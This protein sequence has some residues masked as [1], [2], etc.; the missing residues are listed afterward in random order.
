[1]DIKMGLH[2]LVACTM[3]VLPAFYGDIISASAQMTIK[4]AVSILL[5]GT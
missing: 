3:M 2:A 5:V 4:S 1:M